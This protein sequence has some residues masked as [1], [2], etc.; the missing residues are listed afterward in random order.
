[1]HAGRL[2]QAAEYIENKKRSF[3]YMLSI[4]MYFA[5]IHNMISQQQNI[6]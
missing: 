1:M 4:Y 5:N 2:Q 3:P 6:A